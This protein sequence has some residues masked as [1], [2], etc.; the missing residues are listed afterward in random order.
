[1]EAPRHTLKKILVAID[2]SIYARPTLD[3]AAEIAQNAD[4]RLVVFNVIN[5]NEIDSVEKEVNSKYPNTFVL[6]KHLASEI[7]RR[8][9]K[10][11]AL[12][13]EILGSTQLPV[14][15]RIGHGRPHV[16]ILKA[17]DREEADLLVFGP[18]GRSNLN[19][20]LFG[21]VA[22]KLFRHSP[23]PVMSLRGPVEGTV[24]GSQ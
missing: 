11:E 12:T 13:K 7:S 1:M 22:E 5:Q 6:A 20:F 19:G 17:I 8:E 15:I 3:Y 21:S 18:K 14:E 4:A 9:L 23:V 10:I 2:F 24:K 16:E